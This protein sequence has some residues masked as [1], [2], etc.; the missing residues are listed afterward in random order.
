MA[1]QKRE[2]IN[3][4][5][6]TITLDDGTQQTVYTYTVAQPNGSTYKYRK[7]Y[8]KKGYT[9]NGNNASGGKTGKCGRK[10]IPDALKEKRKEL[11]NSIKKMDVAQ[12]DKLNK[13]IEV[14]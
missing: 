14:L 10:R 6:E 3:K 2:V 13:L 8:T 9:N 1:E 7:R 12:L 4:E 11:E 5:I